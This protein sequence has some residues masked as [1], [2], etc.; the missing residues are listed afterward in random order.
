MKLKA[1]VFDTRDEFVF[2]SDMTEI[3]IR[4]LIKQKMV[5]PEDLSSLL[6]TDHRSLITV[7]LISFHGFS[8]ETV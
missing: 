8:S 2:K 1:Y 4:E 6:V 5:N 3:V 7:Y